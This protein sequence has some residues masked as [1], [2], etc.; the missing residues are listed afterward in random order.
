MDDVTDA[1]R[2]ESPGSEPSAESESDP[3][4]ISMCSCAQSATEQTR[5]AEINF[6]SYINALIDTLDSIV[7]SR[8]GLPTQYA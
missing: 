5:H 3:V 2:I 1:L 8:P 4:L 7:F 6:N